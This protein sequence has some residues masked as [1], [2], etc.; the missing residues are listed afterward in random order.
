MRQNPGAFVGFLEDWF[1]SL[2]HEVKRL[3]KLMKKHKERRVTD[4]SYGDSLYTGNEDVDVAVDIGVGNKSA[5]RDLRAEF[6]SYKRAAS[7]GGGGGGYGGGGGGPGVK[8]PKTQRTTTKSLSAA[9]DMLRKRCPNMGNVPKKA[10][11]L[12]GGKC[13]ACGSAFDKQRPCCVGK[14]NLSA[15]IVAKIKALPVDATE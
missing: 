1:P 7:H 8:K 4:R 10:L 12:A 11:F 14:A 6:E 2:K 5:L 9:I 3:L 15:D 13:F